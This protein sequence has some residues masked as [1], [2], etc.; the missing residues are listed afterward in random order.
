M[1]QNVF[2]FKAENLNGMCQI[3]SLFTWQNQS[4]KDECEVSV[5][6]LAIW[7][8]QLLHYSLIVKILNVQNKC[9]FYNFP[10]WAYHKSTTE[11]SSPTAECLRLSFIF[12]LFFCSIL[13]SLNCFFKFL[14]RL[15][16]GLASAGLG[17][18]NSEQ[19]FIL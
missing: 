13:S 3:Y 9:I 8:V 11:Q 19:K 1:I 7:Y 12:I 16:N 14:G 5:W 10:V 17:Q 6:G 18:N 15:S 2:V 4:D